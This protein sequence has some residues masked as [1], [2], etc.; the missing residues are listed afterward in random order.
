MIILYEKFCSCIIW[1]RNVWKLSCLQYH[2]PHK[3]FYSFIQIANYFVRVKILV[4]FKIFS[5]KLF[6]YTVAQKKWSCRQK[7][8]YVL[9]LSLASVSLW[10]LSHICHCYSFIHYRHCKSKG[11]SRQ[12]KLFVGI[13]HEL[14]QPIK[15]YTKTNK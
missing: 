8:C 4:P 9:I 14:Y 3:N 5:L 10:S 12:A 11:K 13:L 2:A 1:K 15:Y 7:V 6:M